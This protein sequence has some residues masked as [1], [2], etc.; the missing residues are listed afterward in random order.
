MLASLT[1]IAFAFL[2][3][4]ETAHA[5]SSWNPTLLVNTESFQTI[6]SGDAS[7]NIELRFGENADKRIFWN[8]TGAGSGTFKFSKGVYVQGNLTATG[9]LS[10][11]KSISGAVLRVDGGADIWGTLGVSGATVLKSTATINGATKVR[12]SISGATLR[13]DGGADIWGTLG[14]TGATVLKSTLSVKKAISGATL[15]LDGGADIWG[16][17]SATGSL[18]TKSGAII[19]ADNDSNDA[20]LQFGNTT[21]PQTLKFMNARQRFLFSKDVSVIG[22]LSGSSLTVDNRT[23]TIGTTLYTWPSAQGAASTF[24]KNDGAGALTWSAVTVGSSSGNILS[25]HPEYNN[26]VYFASGS[27]TVGTLTYASSGALDNYYRWTT[28]RTTAQDYWISVRVQVP[29]NFTH[30][31]TASGI[32]LRLRTAT[33]QLADN[34]V[35]ARLVD[36]ANAT[37]ALTSNTTLTGSTVNTWRTH[38]LQNVTSGTYTA[39]GY[40]TVLLKLAAKSTGWIDVGFVNFNWSTTTP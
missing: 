22:T 31:D 24:L 19:N 2:I 14:V 32:Q 33:R 11:K 20:I 10:V 39:G 38:T 18:K 9:T 29:K 37:V 35:T 40:I 4:A 15:R 17:L 34:Y 28:T 3:V 21:A 26:A 23:T 1:G 8:I 5:A 13:I 6:D 27:T 7:T 16:N 12:G 25:L 36:T 30:F